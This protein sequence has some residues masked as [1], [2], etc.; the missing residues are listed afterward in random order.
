MDDTKSLDGERSIASLNEAKQ[1]PAKKL[2]I[3]IAFSTII[4][5]LVGLFFINFSNQKKE[6]VNTNQP[7][8]KNNLPQRSFLEPPTA[9]AAPQPEQ[10]VPLVPAPQLYASAPPPPLP[11]NDSAN[12][13]KP[14]VDKSSSGLMVVSNDKSYSNNQSTAKNVGTSQSGGFGG[15]NTNGGGM[16]DMLN[17]TK[18]DTRKA[19][20]AINQTYLLAKGAMINCVL[21]TKLVSTVP[22]MASC[23]VSRDIY[24]DNGKMLLVDKGSEMSGEY[25][26][27]MKQGMA[28]IFVLWNRIKT[29]KGVIVNLDS[30]GTDPLGAAGLPGYIDTHFGERF[31]GAIL[32]SMID[33]AA[34]YATHQSGSN[35]TSTTNVNFGNTTQ[36]AQNMASEALKNSIN[37]PPT[38]YKNQGEEIG[39]FVARDLDFSSVYDAE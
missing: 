10:V 28:R 14:S 25:G 17:G 39:I 30:P 5:V 27:N 9:T 20:F 24:S 31:G 38:L 7:Q 12:L 35:T 37:I 21:Q 29:P 32:V 34:Y 15:G 33:D 11:E 16:G 26:A 4:L 3:F 22:G 8:V 13:S 19:G 36:A 2:F 6:P 18:T 1:S 23:I